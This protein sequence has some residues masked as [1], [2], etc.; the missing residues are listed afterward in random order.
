MIVP[1]MII[2]SETFTIEHGTEKEIYSDDIM[3]IY[4]ETE[5]HEGTYFD[6]YIAFYRIYLNRSYI[7]TDAQKAY[8]I[9]DINGFRRAS[10]FYN[11]EGV[12][13]FPVCYT[14]SGSTYGEFVTE[15][16]EIK[17]I[18]D[19]KQY[20]ISIGLQYETSN[21][22]AD[23]MDVTIYGSGHVNGVYTIGENPFEEGV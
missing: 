21:V 7:P 11:D 13:S 1:Y 23:S 16:Y 14:T 22:T 8:I 2:P 5:K 3:T 6:S 9:S 17:W 20:C 18:V 15:A 10:L 12:Y 4:I 19:D